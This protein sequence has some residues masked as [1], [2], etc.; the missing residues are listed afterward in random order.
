[1]PRIAFPDFPEF[2]PNMTPQQMFKIGIMGGSY[3]RT[4]KSPETGKVYKDRHKKY[5]K[6]LKHIPPMYYAQQEY[7]KSINFYG[8]KVGT[9]YEYWMS[10]HWI[11]E[12]IDPFGWIEWYCNFYLGR[13]TSDDRRQID[14]WLNLAGQNGRFRKQLQNKINSIG[15]N[16]ERIYPRMRQTLLHW[17]F[18]S[19][20]MKVSSHG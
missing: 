8:V 6:L 9:S 12:D 3:F 18:D 20:K 14:R 15:S 11:K 1:M 10:K 4:I 13:R 2:K 17:A 16:D 19:R 5:N 7:D